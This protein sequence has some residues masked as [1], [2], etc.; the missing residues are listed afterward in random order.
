[1]FNNEED[2][3]V[4]LLMPFL[5]D[6]GFDESEISLEDRFVI[7][8]GRT[9]QTIQGKSDL[10]CRRQGRNLFIIELKR[11]S[12]KIKQQDVEQGISYARALVDN[13]APFTIITNGKDTRI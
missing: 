5:S 2:I 7:R 8:L 12:H 1:M 10:L 11:D 9:T 13:I 6:L 3:R 4:K